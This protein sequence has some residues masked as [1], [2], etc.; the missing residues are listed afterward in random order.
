MAEKSYVLVE[1]SW[2]KSG[3]NTKTRPVARRE[4]KAEIFSLKRK[5]KHIMEVDGLYGARKCLEIW[6]VEPAFGEGHY[7]D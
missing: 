2:D 5:L 3:V 7:I 1:V 6:E 4:Y